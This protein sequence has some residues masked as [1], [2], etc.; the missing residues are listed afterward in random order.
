MANSNYA[1]TD[2][3]TVS[4]VSQCDTDVLN[5]CLMHLKYNHRTSGG[6]FSLFD[7]KITDHVLSGDE[8]LGWVIQGGVVTMTYP[9]AV[10]VI[11]E[12][13]SNGVECTDGDVTYMLS[14]T[15]RRIADISQYE[16]VDRLYETKGHAPY[17]VYDAVN[18]QFYLPKTKLLQQ[19]TTNTDL[20]NTVNEAGL[21]NITGTFGGTRDVVLQRAG[22]LPGRSGPDFFD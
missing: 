6:G 17:Y 22:G 1:W 8:A 20:V 21:P 16:A 19:F 5:D 9:D 15:G 2:N 18:Q 7:T 11:K 3:P 13:Y 4:G 14:P 12:E 10:N